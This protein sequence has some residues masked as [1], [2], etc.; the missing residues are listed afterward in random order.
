MAEDKKGFLLYADYIDTFEH[1]TMEQRGEVIWWILQYV[2]DK[3]PEP[4]SG[5]LMAVIAN[6]RAQL[7]R[8]LDKYEEK[9]GRSSESGRIGN[10]KRWHPDLYDEYKKG[11]YTLKGAESIADGRKL[12]PPDPTRSDLIAKIAVN[13]NVSGNVTVTGKG[14]DND[15]VKGKGIKENNIL[16][17]SISDESELDNVEHITF[18]FWKLFKANL[19]E[20]GITNTTTLD[21]ATLNK[22]KTPI[23]LSIEKDGRTEEEFRELFRFLSKNDFWKKNIQS[24]AKLRE[25]F[26]RLLVEARSKTNTTAH[27]EVPDDI[28]KE[29]EE[30]AKR[31]ANNYGR[32]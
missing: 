16:L 24:T 15:T 13:D 19:N 23:R 32:D 21:K 14:K 20:V 3:H 12:S 26:E 18:S 29:L 28:R 11:V 25:Q 6:I 4:L 17:C 9:R 8:D 1:L 2:N 22:W 7:K 31:R 5:L 30:I 10:L 27:G